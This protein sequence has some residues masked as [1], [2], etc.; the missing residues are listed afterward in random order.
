MW[1]NA[2]AVDRL[3]WSVLYSAVYY[4]DL[5]TVTLLLQAG[6]DAQHGARALDGG[7]RG[8]NGHATSLHV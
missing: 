7:S 8:I 3:G 6:A 1:G 4:Q 2:I 5:E